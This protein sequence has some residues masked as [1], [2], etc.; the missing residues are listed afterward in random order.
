MSSDHFCAK[1]SKVLDA[2][3]D[4]FKN[5]RWKQKCVS[6][7]LPA[8]NYRQLHKPLRKRQASVDLTNP[9]SSGPRLNPLSSLLRSP[10]P[11]VPTQSTESTNESSSSSFQILGLLSSPWPLG[12]PSSH[13]H[14][15]QLVPQSYLNRFSSSQLPSTPSLPPLGSFFDFQPQPSNPHTEDDVALNISLDQD[16]ISLND[17][18]EAEANIYEMPSSPPRID[19]STEGYLEKPALSDKDLARITK[20]YQELDK[21]TIETCNICHRSWFR[22]HVYRNECSNCRNDR[23]KYGGEGNYI[24]LFGSLNNLDPGPMPPNLPVLT[25]IEEMLLARVHVFMEIR[26]HRGVQYKYRGHICHFTVNVGKVFNRLPLLPQDLDIIILKPP[27]SDD[28]D[29]AAINRQFR[30]DYR[31]RRPVVIQWLQHLRAHH[32]G[33]SD[34]EFNEAAL[35]ALPV[36]GYVDGQL[37]VIEY[38]QNQ[39]VSPSSPHQPPETRPNTRPNTTPNTSSDLLPDSLPDPP[40]A[41][42]ASTITPELPDEDGEGV[43]SPSTAYGS[44]VWDDDSDEEEDIPPES[45]AVPDLVPDLGEFEALRQQIQQRTRDAF[46]SMGSIRRTPIHEFNRQEALLSLA[47]PSLYPTGAAEFVAPRMREVSFASYAKLMMCYQ[48]GRFARHPR[49][50]YAVFNTLLRK[51]STEKAGFF[52]KRHS[53]GEDM[54]ADDIQAAFDGEDG[55]QQLVD[56]VVRWSASVRGTRAYWNAE[57]KKLEA[58]V[59]TPLTAHY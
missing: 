22:L 53:D 1:C 29:P 26:Q 15:P 23:V 32:P 44:S 20:F 8:R 11:P 37:T 46:L 13:S 34:I 47:F 48:D 49:F 42:F 38:S 27:A 9:I 52:V 33:Y 58:L 16:S 3:I 4:R 35:Q 10:A 19:H 50:R 12:L 57:G 28:D 25:A 24:P 45:A 18:L 2:H 41:T 17:F 7:L 59:C 21:L 51:Q 39:P 30:K 55:G 36:D 6:C 43:N 40:V 31:V 56:S 5:G 54:T 14:S